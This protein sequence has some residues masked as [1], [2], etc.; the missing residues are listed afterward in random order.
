MPASGTYVGEV[1]ERWPSPRA[2]R[3][4]FSTRHAP[5]CPLRRPAAMTRCRPSGFPLARVAERQRP[6]FC[7][8]CASRADDIRNRY[9]L[10]ESSQPLEH[11]DRVD[12]GGGALVQTQ[13]REGEQELPATA[14]LAGGP[15]EAAELHVVDQVHGSSLRSAPGT[16]RRAPPH[17]PNA[18]A[19]R[20]PAPSSFDRWIRAYVGEVGERW[21]SPR[22]TRLLFSTRHAPRCPLR[23]PAAMTRCRPSGFPLARV[24]ERQRPA[25]CGACASRADDIRNR[26]HSASPLNH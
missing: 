25:F 24:A 2:T 17:P 18:P 23:R 12:R 1:G 13:R 19:A 9:S 8:A 5:R 6:A 7:G 4:L 22:A 26:Y 3:L 20:Q 11:R 16:A 14:L 15:G 21:P 10:C